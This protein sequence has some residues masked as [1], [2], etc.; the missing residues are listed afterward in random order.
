M[1]DASQAAPPFPA[2]SLIATLHPEAESRLHGYLG[3]I[4]DI[5]RTKRR[6]E[7]FAIYACGIL[8]DGERKSVEPIAARACGSPEEADAMHRKLLRFVGESEW[9]DRPLREYAARYAIEQMEVRGPI[10]HWIMD[11]TGFIKQG[12]FSPGVQRQYT[13]SA[14]KTTNCQVAVSL[15]L[16]SDHAHVPVDMQLY[17]PESWAADRKRCRA[18]GIPDDVEYQPKWMIG[19]KMIEAAVA[20]GLPQ[21]IVLADADYGNKSAF[22]DRLDALQLRYAVAVKKTTCVRRVRGVGKRRKLGE[23]MSVEDLAFELDPKDIRKV[24]W[25]E[26]TNATM[27]ARFAVVRVEPAPSNGPLRRE[28]W[29]IIEWPDDSHLPTKYNLATLPRHRSRKHLIRVLKERW[30]TERAYEDLKGE[31]GLDHFEGR[32]YRGWN[33]HVTIVLA[34]FA[35]LVAEQARAFPPSAVGADASPPDHALHRAA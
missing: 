16:A 32:T 26:G 12:K 20:A 24:T 7:G 18:A 30:R 3:G 29:L 2:P 8:G 33:H 17:L 13:G 27:S 34:C 28:Q 31:L 4:F 10:R 14:G 11:D 22:R 35:F 19:L 1:T 6:R 25:R 15:T 5:L 23:R 21:G 9:E